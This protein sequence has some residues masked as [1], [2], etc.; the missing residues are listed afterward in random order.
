MSER[1]KRISKLLASASSRASYI[2]AK[3]NVLIPSQIRALRLKNNDM[4]Q[5]QLAV[6]ADMAQ[7][8]ISAME[9]P[10]ETKFN[11]E[12]LVRLAAAFKIGLKVE[13]VSFSEMLQWENNYSQDNF[14]IVQ[15]DQDGAFINPTAAPTW[16]IGAELAW[17]KL[18]CRASERPQLTFAYHTGPNVREIPSGSGSFTYV[19]VG[20]SPRQEFAD[21]QATPVLT[22]QDVISV[23]AASPLIH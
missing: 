4:T 11:I 13:F 10:G 2:R 18:L 6:L 3:L 17:K 12:T 20:D 22:H 14:N 23:Q 5:K 16:Q 15:I 21:I 8:R 19:G 9:R 7:P 1:S